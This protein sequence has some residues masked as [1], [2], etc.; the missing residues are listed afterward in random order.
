[1]SH[2]AERDLAGDLREAIAQ[3]GDLLL[4]YLPEVS[5]ASGRVVAMSALARW[6]H[7]DHG[8]IPPRE[9]IDLAIEHRLIGPLTEWVLKTAFRQCRVWRDDGLPLT[10]SVNL[11]PANL[12][13]ERL[14]QLVRAQARA[15]AVR[16]EWI[17]LE[18]PEATVLGADG[19]L[20]Q[21]AA[22]LRAVGVVLVVDNAGAGRDT[23]AAIERTG[24][25]AIKLDRE[26]I[27]HLADERAAAR[28]RAAIGAAKA[29]GA[30][31]IAE[32]V[33]DRTT[34]D[35]LAALG[36]D[37]ALGYLISPPLSPTDVAAWLRNSPWGIAGGR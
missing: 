31:V 23:A 36:C 1:M 3:G 5:L 34:Y 7:P 37:A 11:S 16:P 12:V 20:A 8:M 22:A 13:D 27:A 33:E 35:T 14:P 21:L 32:G 30:A 28:A 10:V 9:F 18:L 19:H 4:H 26:V 6:N 2:S 25:A 15:L 24:C 17:R 29:R